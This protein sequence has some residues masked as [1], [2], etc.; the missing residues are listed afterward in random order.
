[1]LCLTVLSITL[2]LS[3]LQLQTH[4]HHYHTENKHLDVSH[5]FR[6]LKKRSVIHSAPTTVL[7]GAM[8]NYHGLHTGCCLEGVYLITLQRVIIVLLLLAPL[9]GNNTGSTHTIL[10][11]L[12]CL[13]ALWSLVI[14]TCNQLEPPHCIFCDIRWPNQKWEDKATPH[15]V[16]S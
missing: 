6:F 12:V 1:M 13:W 8:N 15:K 11:S 2:G 7:I 14:S 10:L 5:F 16:K 9:D 3:F 4:H